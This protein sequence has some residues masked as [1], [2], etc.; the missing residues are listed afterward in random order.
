MLKR[1]D[2]RA[3]QWTKNDASRLIQLEFSFAPRTSEQ[4]KCHD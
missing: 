3:L 1:T 4:Q 2:W